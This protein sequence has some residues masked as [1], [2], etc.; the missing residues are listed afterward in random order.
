MHQYLFYLSGFP[1]VTLIYHPRNLGQST[2]GQKML[3]IVGK[4]TYFVPFRSW[5]KRT[6][7]KFN[8]I[9]QRCMIFLRSP[10]SLQIV[11][12]FYKFVEEGTYTEVW[13]LHSL[14]TSYVE[15]I[16][17]VKSWRLTN[18]LCNSCLFEEVRYPNEKKEWGSSYLWYRR[19]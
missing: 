18:I 11:Q 14:N 10:T 13:K 12:F 17:K 6:R 15:N 9:L 7:L 16:Y 19:N 2:Y 5:L 8:L 1:L 3:K 4:V